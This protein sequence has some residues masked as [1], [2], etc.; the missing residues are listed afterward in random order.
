MRCTLLYYYS[1]LQPPTTATAI[2]APAKYISATTIAA[3]T[4]YSV[5]L[6][7]P[8][9][10]NIISLPPTPQYYITTTAIAAT[11]NYITTTAIAAT[12]NYNIILLPPTQQ[13]YITTNTIAATAIAANANYSTLPL[14]T[15]LLNICS[16]QLHNIIL[17]LPPTILPLPTLLP[18]P[19][20]QHCRYFQLYSS[21]L[22]PT[23]SY[24]TDGVWWKISPNLCKGI[25]DME[26]IH[27]HPDFLVVLYLNG[28]GSHL[29]PQP[30]LFFS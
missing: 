26:G 23:T 25:R 6:L 28:H 3:T 17:P 7:L 4:N 10:L 21:L 16:C 27:N 11:A 13:Y 12:A 24:M 9:L 5:S 30:L 15:T 18:L 8:P 22:P 14:L 19:T 20:T 1:Y 29:D 2:A